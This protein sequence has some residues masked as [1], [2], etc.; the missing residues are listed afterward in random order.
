MSPTGTPMRC[1]ASRHSP[2]MTLAVPS[3]PNT[4]A[5]ATLSAALDDRPDPRGRVEVMWSDPPVE[6]RAN[7]VTAATRRAQAG[8]TDAMVSGSGTSGKLAS[9]PG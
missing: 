8:A 7:D 2:A 6:G 4:S 1:S 9:S 3:T 5:R